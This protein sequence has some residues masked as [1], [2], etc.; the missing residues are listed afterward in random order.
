[1][2]GL[3]DEFESANDEAMSLYL[4]PGLPQ[5][6]VE[7]LLQKALVPQAIVQDIA[8]FAT[9]SWTGAVLF[10]GTTRSYLVLPPFPVTDKYIATGYDGEPLR[11]Q[12]EANLS[13]ALVLVRLGAFTIG[14]CQGEKLVTSKTGTGLVHARHK[15]GGS[16]QRR[17][18]RHRE[19]QVD[20][21]LE[22]VCSHVRQQ[23]EPYASSLEYV[24]YGG[25]RTTI[26]SLREHCPFLKKFEDR[27]LPPLLDIPRPR[28]SVLEAAIGTVWSCNVTEWLEDHAI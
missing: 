8:G 9:S 22:R 4:P 13:I 23:L 10:W 20:T 27:T 24:V 12:L 21:F 6:Q 7:D 1:M 3:L 16:S 2:L 11:S 5:S 15:K 28:R 17:F 19:K 26:H 14:V 25:S 18:E